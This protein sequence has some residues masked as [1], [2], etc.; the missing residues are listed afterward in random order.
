[1][2]REAAQVV[3]VDTQVRQVPKPEAADM[4]KAH[5]PKHL[6]HSNLN[7]ALDHSNLNKAL[8]HSNLKHHVLKHH[9]LKHHVLKHHVLKHHVLKHHGLKRTVL[10]HHG[11]KRTVLKDHALKLRGLNVPVVSQAT[12]PTMRDPMSPS[13]FVS[14]NTLGLVGITHALSV[15]L[16]H[17]IGI[18]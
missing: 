1:M 8:D 12:A 2:D 16:I 5:V 17:S 4:N 14:A 6:D 10:K 18:A 11:L 15:L 7:K 3:A 13:A 9:V